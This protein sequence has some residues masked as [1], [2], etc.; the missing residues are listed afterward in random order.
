MV[1]GHDRRRAVRGQDSHVHR[2]G[3]V[4]R[5]AGGDLGVRYDGDLGGRHR[6]GPDEGAAAAVGCRPGRFDRRA[7]SVVDRPVEV[8]TSVSGLAGSAG[9]VGGLKASEIKGED[10]L[11]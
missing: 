7:G 10:G 9:R 3:G 6:V 4:D 8:E 2:A 11:R 5:R 1:R